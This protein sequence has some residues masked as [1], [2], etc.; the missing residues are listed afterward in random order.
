MEILHANR[1]LKNIDIRLDRSTCARSIRQ[2]AISFGNR[3]A[4]RE[5]SNDNEPEKNLNRPIIAW[6]QSTKLV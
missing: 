5:N 3:Q 2:N 1:L 4:E 6:L